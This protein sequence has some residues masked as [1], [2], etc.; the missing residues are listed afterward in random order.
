MGDPAA[1]D[2][3]VKAVGGGVRAASLSHYGSRKDPELFMFIQHEKQK[4][5][6]AD[7]TNDEERRDIT[8]N[9][10]QVSFLTYI[11]P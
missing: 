10:S 5:E 7:W 6:E 4:K 11:N 2:A 3:V 9:S 1:G 8:Q